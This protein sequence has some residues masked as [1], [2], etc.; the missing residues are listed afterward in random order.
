MIFAK[1]DLDSTLVDTGELISLALAEQGYMMK[2]E[3]QTGWFY[4]F[5]EGHE[6]PPDFQWEVFFYRLL[7]ER[8]DE[9]KP[10]DIFVNEFLEKIS[11]GGDPVHVI[12][13]R[14]NG[15]IMHH[16]CM[17]TLE[18]CF[19]N[20]EFHVSVLK[21]GE[22]KLKYMGECDIMFEDRRKTALQLSHAGNVVAMPNMSY[23]EIPNDGDNYVVDIEACGTPGPGDIIRYDNF[24][25]VL[26]SSLL[27]FSRPF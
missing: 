19:P 18:R 17:S 4:E 27:T 11:A 20:V 21:S 23:N 15:V 16:A 9:L 1:F 25:Q 22:D 10:V 13:A 14:T 2:P 26:E 5:I 3:P 7:T 12:T 8:L 6:P 24:G